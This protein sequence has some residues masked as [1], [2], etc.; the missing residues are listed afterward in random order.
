MSKKQHL[1]DWISLQYTAMAMAALGSAG[2][3]FLGGLSSSLLVS[4]LLG[5]S[6]LARPSDKSPDSAAHRHFL[7]LLLGGASN[8][9]TSAIEDLSSKT[10]SIADLRLKAKRH[11][12]ALGIDT[13]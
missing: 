12:E 6:G 1:S 13:D 2:H 4:S 9:T 7:P 10:S 8:T 11:Q 5:G 3:A